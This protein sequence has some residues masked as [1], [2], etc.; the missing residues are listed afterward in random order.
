MQEIKCPKCG[1]VF[2]VD[3]TGY[4]RIVRQVRDKEFFN[5]M[6][7][8]EKESAAMRK[9]EFEL[10]Q[11]QDAQKRAAE[12]A[13]KEAELS[14]KDRLQNYKQNWKQVKQRKSSL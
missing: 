11:M 4:E 6:E 13:K 5:E 14:V 7:R 9:K 2:Q 1:E 10:I 8:R 12:I 3:E